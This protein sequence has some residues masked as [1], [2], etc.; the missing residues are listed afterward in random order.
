MNLDHQNHDVNLRV[1]WMPYYSG[2][3]SS[4][5]SKECYAVIF[6]SQL[7]AIDEEYHRVA[8]RMEA[9]A[10]SMPG[11]LGV[12]SVRNDLTAITVS[13]WSSEEAIHQWRKH[14]EHL[15]AQARGKSWWYQ[16]YTLRV[17]KVSRQVEFKK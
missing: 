3:M 14:P 11:F 1:Y 9:L 13:Y 7:T 16:R 15:D 17:A 2:S 4:T 8:A 12:E 10:Q 6:S 5:A